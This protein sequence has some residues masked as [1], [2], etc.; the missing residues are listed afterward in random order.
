M[1][2]QG[3]KVLVVGAG[4]SGVDACRFLLKQGA[5]VILTDSKSRERLSPEALSLEKQGVELR[6]GNILP[7]QVD[8]EQV[9]ASPG[10]PLGLPVFTMSRNAG[11]EVIGEIELAWRT[12]SRPFIGITG[13]NGKTTTTA[14][15]AYLLQQQNYDV[16]LGGNIG[17]P[18]V[19]TIGDFRGDYV[20]AELS[21]FQLE[22]CRDFHPHIAAFLNLSPDHLDRH[23]SLENYAA[24]KAKIFARQTKEDFA[25]LNWD[26]PYL[27]ELAPSLPGTI[28]W[29]SLQEPVENGMYFREGQVFFVRDGQI[30][31]DFSAADIYIKGRHNIANAMAASIAAWEA[32]AAPEN[33]AQGLRTFPGVPHRLEFVCQRDGVSYVNDSK[34]TNPDSTTQ[35]LLAYE[36]PIVILLGGRNKG[37]DM[38]PLLQLVKERARLAILFGEATAELK[39]AADTAGFSAYQIADDFTH[40]VSLAR[41]A[42]KAGDVVLL[43]PACTSWDAFPNFEVRGDLFKKLVR[44]E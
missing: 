7:E 22:S 37:C 3:K 11:V 42:A 5:G 2:Y 29:F 41:S 27:R 6:L 30:V 21:S 43:S 12:A 38:L 17:Q 20:V 36:Q 19:S 16:L 24:A 14:L 1:D 23:G 28:R 10:V 34:G 32:G 13:T 40:A 39:R 4:L 9:V 25:I 18:L 35:A 26:D 15:T 8:W 44:E 33:I 31:Y